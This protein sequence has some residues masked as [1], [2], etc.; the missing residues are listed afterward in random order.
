MNQTPS[1]SSRLDVNGKWKVV[2][3]HVRQ[4]M[5]HAIG[6]AT[7]REGTTVSIG[8]FQYQAAGY[9]SRISCVDFAVS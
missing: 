2:G 9:G 8:Y 4:S 7:W 1:R 3:H 5:P 6:D